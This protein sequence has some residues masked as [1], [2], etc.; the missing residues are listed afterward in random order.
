MQA[1]SL[2][3]AGIRTGTFF[4][5]F[6]LLNER[7]VIELKQNFRN[8]L[9]C[10]MAALCTGL[11]MAALPVLHAGAYSA[12]DVAA[13]A[14]E[15][16]WPEYL[17]QAGYSE[18]QSGNYSQEQLDQAYGSVASYNEQSGQVIA[19]SLGVRYHAVESV[20][21]TEAGDGAETS[22]TAAASD[23]AEETADAADGNAAASTAS[24][25]LTVT[26]T[27]GTTEERISK[28]EFVSM[29]L[30]EKQDYIAG[31]TLESQEAFMATLSAEERNSVLKQLPTE[32]KVKLVQ[33]YIDAAKDMGMNVAVDEL[34]GSDISLTI[35]NEEGKVIG[36]TAIGTVVDETGISHTMPLMTALAAAILSVTALAI[37]NRK[38]N[39]QK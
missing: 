29:T 31:L 10:T 18:W 35:R 3:S 22:D 17:V 6:L 15:A 4:L 16:G 11:C 12:D 23:T 32:D 39:R 38:N 27:D 24:T 20:A 33:T 19:A 2:P 1:Y 34:S 5:F 28:S 9:R 30:E 13:K 25:P 21:A 37:L 36:K 14:R 7:Q 8:Q 26:K